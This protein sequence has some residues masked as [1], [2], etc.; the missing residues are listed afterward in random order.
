MSTTPQSV[1]L[2]EVTAADI[3]GGASAVNL[4]DRTTEARLD[5]LLRKMRSGKRVFLLDW[6]GSKVPR[7][8]VIDGKEIAWTQNSMV[9]STERK[10]I[11]TYERTVEYG[12]ASGEHHQ[13]VIYM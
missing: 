5:S 11:G 4:G 3:A 6:E 2:R 9:T 8:V 10:H 7:G 13:M 12:G 1:V